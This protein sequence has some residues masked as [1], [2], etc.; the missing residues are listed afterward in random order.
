MSEFYPSRRDAL[1]GLLV[2]MAAPYVV[3]NSG[4]LIPVRDRTILFANELEWQ[5]ILG[6]R[7]CK[8]YPLTVAEVKAWR[9]STNER[10]D[11]S[12]RVS[13]M[14]EGWPGFTGWPRQRSVTRRWGCVRAARHRNGP[15]QPCRKQVTDRVA[16]A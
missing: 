5:T 2:S 16:A 6:T 4:L 13:W 10:L 8:K 12:V 14:G 15:Q 1:A 7:D 11:R 3:R 9:R